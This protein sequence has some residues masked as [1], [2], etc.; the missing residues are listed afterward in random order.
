MLP[1]LISIEQSAM[2]SSIVF[3]LMG[4]VVVIGH[5]QLSLL[6]MGWGTGALTT[7]SCFAE[8]WLKRVY[9]CNMCQI[10]RCTSG[11][12]VLNFKSGVQCLMLTL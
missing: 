5:V 9:Q 8:N 2:V 12:P 10:D 3:V 7:I 6:I 11:F 4:F 1:L